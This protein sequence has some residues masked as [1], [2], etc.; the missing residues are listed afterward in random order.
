MM[1]LL[2]AAVQD[3]H[4]SGVPSVDL[5]GIFASTNDTVYKDDCCHLNALGNRIM[6]DAIVSNVMARHSAGARQSPSR[7]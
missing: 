5:T 1:T 7:F 3:L 4:R 6:A 2:K